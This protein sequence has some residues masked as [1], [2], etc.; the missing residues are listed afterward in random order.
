MR[1][2]YGAI[3]HHTIDDENCSEVIRDGWEAYEAARDDPVKRPDAHVSTTNSLFKVFALT[4][5]GAV[6][7]RYAR[8]AARE[9][10]GR[11]VI[12]TYRTR[13]NPSAQAWQTV[14]LEQDALKTFVG[15]DAEFPLDGLLEMLR[16]VGRPFVARARVL[17]GTIVATTGAG[18]IIEYRGRQ[19]R[20]GMTEPQG[21]RGALTSRLPK[22][23][24]LQTPGLGASIL[25]T[26]T[27]L[28]QDVPVVSAESGSFL[29][30]ALA[31]LFWPIL[32]H[33]RVDATMIR[34]K[35][36]GFISAP[37]NIVS[38]IEVDATLCEI[39]RF[40]GLRSLLAIPEHVED[41]HIHDATWCAERVAERLFRGHYRI[42]EASEEGLTL[43]SIGVPIP[44][45]LLFD[46]GLVV[47]KLS[48]R[49]ELHITYLRPGGKPWIM[50]LPLVRKDGFGA[51]KDNDRGSPAML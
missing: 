17:V 1:T 39:A 5:K 40:L 15:L 50:R 22:G 38:S 49:P 4:A 51:R 29:K 48:R 25:F 34:S 46:F 36:L 21:S 11:C 7:G 12:E 33:H 10:F 9:V 28:Q 24:E 14:R 43:D 23:P 18:I 26:S 30:N 35:G 16:G 13:L 44:D 20:M 47:R 6:S 37:A 27:G 41:R 19:F 42:I 2:I 45:A 3:P 8:R 31:T 32:D